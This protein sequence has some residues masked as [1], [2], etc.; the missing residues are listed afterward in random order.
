MSDLDDTTANITATEFALIPSVPLNYSVGYF[1]I[2]VCAWRA[3]W[4]TVPLIK[5]VMGKNKHW[6]SATP[7]CHFVSRLKATVK[8]PLKS[9]KC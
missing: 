9:P 6:P 3:Q 5:Q 8:E 1:N 4:P 7:F 2:F